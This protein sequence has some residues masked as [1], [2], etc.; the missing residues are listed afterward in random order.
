MP[1]RR[2]FVVAGAG[3]MGSLVAWQLVRSGHRVTV[4][5]K[6]PVDAPAS[7]GHTAAAMV[8]PF[9]ERPVSTPWVFSLG[10]QSLTLWPRL[11]QQLEEDSGERVGFHQR[12]SLLVAHPLDMSELDELH[13][14]MRSF[15]LGPK[16]GVAELDGRGIGELEPE[17]AG[18]FSKG[19]YID[20]EAHVDNRQL[21]A[22]LHR[23]IVSF[24]GGI[25]YD[26]AVGI[27]N[28]DWFL[29]R[30]RILADGFIDT[31][32]VG[33]RCWNA[34]VRGVRGEVLWIHSPGTRISR[35]VRL[36]HPRY[37]LYLVP[38]GQDRYILGATEIESD[39]RSPVT[40]RSALELLSALYTVS[41]GFGE[42]TILEMGVNLRP[43]LPDHQ[44]SIDVRDHQVAINGLFRHGYLLAPAVL[45]QLQQQVDWFEQ[46]V[47][48]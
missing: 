30:E 23:T 14:S 35:P 45:Q 12:G 21:L 48:I 15:G 19:M 18:R 10:Q 17:L 22:C 20:S 39:D 26:T 32:G 13:A 27:D 34:D 42:A 44:P 11:L 9:S 6:S 33:A 36:L 47:A 37:R 1:D 16:Q 29:G 8:A 25:H 24:G 4:Y 28:G 5:E 41:P 46:E 2:H 38:K 43:A 31:C 3:L 40:V 7:A